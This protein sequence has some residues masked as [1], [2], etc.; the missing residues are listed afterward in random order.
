MPPHTNVSGHTQPD[1]DEGHLPAAGEGHTHIEMYAPRPLV[2]PRVFA[3]LREAITRIFDSGPSRAEYERH[4]DYLEAEARR[5]DRMAALARRFA[6][7]DAASLFAFRDAL[8]AA[9]AIGVQLPQDGVP[10]AGTCQSDVF[11]RPD[12]MFDLTPAIET[13]IIAAI[14]ERVDLAREERWIDTAFGVF[15]RLVPVLDI[16]QLEASS[17]LGGLRGPEVMQ[18]HLDRLPDRLPLPTFPSDLQLCF[19]EIGQILRQPNGAITQAT[20]EITPD[21]NSA[22]I[23]VINPSVVCAGAEVELLPIPNDSFAPNRPAG[24]DVLFPQCGIWGE[25]LAWSAERIRV[26]VPDGARS[27]RVYFGR[28]QIQSPSIGDAVVTDLGNLIGVCPMMSGAIGTIASRPGILGYFFMGMPATICKDAFVPIGIPSI[29]IFHRHEILRFAAYTPEG[30]WIQNEPVE[31]CSPITLSWEARSDHTNPPNVRL[32]SGNA[33][34]AQG[35]SLSGSTALPARSSFTLEIT[36]E[37][38]STTTTINLAL[39]R[40]L[41]ADPPIIVVLPGGSATVK[42]SASCPVDQDL[43]ITIANSAGGPELPRVT[44]PASAVIAAGSQEVT[45]TITGIGFGNPGTASAVLTLTAQGYDPATI[46]VW[47]EKPDGLWVLLPEEFNLDMVPIHAALVHTGKV[48][49]FSGDE[50]PQR[51]NDIDRAKT[52]LWNPETNTFEEIQWGHPRNMFCGG[53]CH[54][55]D[56]RVLVA[57]GQAFPG[58]GRGA[59]HDIHTFDPNTETWSRHGDMLR[60]RWYPTCV[61]LP[62]G[63]VLIVSGYSAGVKPNPIAELSGQPVN[64]EWDRFDP[65]N[66]TLDNSPTLQRFFLAG[67]DLYPFLKLLPGGAIFVHSRD[68]T[69][70]CF[71][72]PPGVSNLGY[73]LPPNQIYLT[74]SSNTRTYPGQGACVLLPIP[75]STG[76]VSVQILV[77]G[78]GDERATSV[79][80]ATTWPPPGS[81]ASV[82]TNTAEIFQFNPAL[83]LTVRQSGW[84]TTASMN[85][86][87]FMSDATLLPDGT[88]LVVGGTAAGQ[89]DNNNEPV[90]ETELFDPVSETWQQMSAQS[91]PRRYHST[92]LLLPDGRVLSVGSTTNW[93]AAPWVQPPP[94]YQPEYRVEVFYP[95]YFFRGPRPQILLLPSV[96]RYAETFD[97]TVSD[98]NQVINAVLIRPAAVT[99]TNDMD[100]RCI[101]LTIVDRNQNQIILR[102]PSDA[103]VA[104]LGYY[105]LFILNERHVPSVGRFLRIG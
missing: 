21:P 72:L 88:V 86:R 71:P 82:A 105:M 54:L 84:R 75:A 76:P 11:S 42:V 66:N 64:E 44:A 74:N 15:A 7:G 73:M 87:R 62:D 16:L 34:L 104:P 50:D 49:F 68:T 3:Q 90:M 94:V 81:V 18:V 35:L 51:L 5:L 25:I 99:H 37:C 27:G 85:Q 39:F 80:G 69:R 93:P 65:S 30:R 24:V 53:Q 9:G 67:I 2:N 40:K 32:L 45:I 12:S 22:K 101:Y 10:D 96:I 46:S 31:D 89:A 59:D 103:T 100:Q 29:T 4:I 38:G 58:L 8:R 60:A 92:A 20:N 61:S 48:L 91:V 26:R 102:S 36:N 33:V 43:Q 78:G 1:D 13:I 77:V 56:G 17:F 14:A 97:V 23:G 83:P 95:P 98:E 63:R 57:G 6:D 70:L 55:P 28:Q 52:H 41:K 47:V 79:R 19:G